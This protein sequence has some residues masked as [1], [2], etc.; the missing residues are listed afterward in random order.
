MLSHVSRLE[1]TEASIERSPRCSPCVKRAVPCRI[2]TR[3]AS[4]EYIARKVNSNDYV[5]ACCRFYSSQSNCL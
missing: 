4:K 3:V 5:Y 1:E 2:Y